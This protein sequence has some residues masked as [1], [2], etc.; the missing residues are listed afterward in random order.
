MGQHPTLYKLSEDT[1]FFSVVGNVCPVKN[2]WSQLS[3]I[4]DLFWKVLQGSRKARQGLL[5]G[6]FQVSG[7]YPASA[8]PK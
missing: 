4:R 8:V 5:V 6:V 1:G 2:L 3:A 7:G